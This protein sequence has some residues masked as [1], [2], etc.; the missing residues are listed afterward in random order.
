MD[1]KRIDIL[2]LRKTHVGDEIRE[3]SKKSN[4]SWF[5]SGG[6]QGATCYHGVAIVIKHELRNYIKDIETIDER[7]MTLTLS[8]HID[9]TIVAAYAPTAIATA[10]DRQIRQ[11]AIHHNNQI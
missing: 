1:S 6:S 7:F 9:V 11:Q 5:L 4:Y 2:V 3:Q 10:E 8:G